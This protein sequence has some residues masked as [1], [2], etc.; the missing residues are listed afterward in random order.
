V[1]CVVCKNKEQERHVLQQSRHCSAAIV[2]WITCG[3][4]VCAHAQV[5]ASQKRWDSACACTWMYYPVCDGWNRDCKCRASMLQHVAQCQNMP[6]KRLTLSSRGAY[7]DEKES[8]IA[9]FPFP[10]CFIAEVISCWDIIIEKMWLRRNCWR[11]CLFP[12]IV[13]QVLH[14]YGCV[15]SQCRSHW[16]TWRE[17]ISKQAQGLWRHGC[18]RQSIIKDKKR[19]TIESGESVCTCAS[20]MSLQQVWRE[21][22]DRKERERAVAGESMREI[23]SAAA[24]EHLLCQNALS[25]VYTHN[26]PLKWTP[27]ASR[28]WQSRRRGSLLQEEQYVCI[29]YWIFFFNLRER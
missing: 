25:A 15:F 13:L 29:V 12:A 4:C 21:S 11:R 20:F 3:I 27:R 17:R 5:H 22:R 18:A 14:L 23:Q 8:C 7:F 1:C 9:T 24:R 2:Y 6:E 16:G 19:C 28:R 10:F 26:S